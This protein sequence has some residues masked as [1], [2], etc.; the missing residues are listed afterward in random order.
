MKYGATTPQRSIVAGLG[1]ILLYSV[2]KWVT[3]AQ[4]GI[5]GYVPPIAGGEGLTTVSP[6][7]RSWLIP[8][9]STLGGLISG[10]LVFGLAPQAE[11]HRTGSAIDAFHNMHLAF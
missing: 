6:V 7:A 1:I 8:L 2:I 3:W 4:L 5:A 9:V 10:L 11:G